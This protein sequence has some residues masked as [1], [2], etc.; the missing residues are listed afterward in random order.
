MSD[1]VERDYGS[2]GHTATYVGQP[3]FGQ[4]GG[5]AGGVAVRFA[6]MPPQFLLGEDDPGYSVVTTGKLTVEWWALATVPATV[7]GGERM[8]AKMLTLT[9]RDWEGPRLPTGEHRFRLYKFGVNLQLAETTFGFPTLGVY[10][11]YVATVENVAGTVTVTTY[12]DGAFV[13]TGT[14]AFSDLGD[15]TAKLGLGGAEDR[16]QSF[17]GT[18]DEVAIYSTKLSAARVLA[19]YQ[20]ANSQAAYTAAVLADSPLSYYHMDGVASPYMQLVPS[21][22]VD[23]VMNRAVGTRTGGD[24]Q[25]WEDV[26]SQAENTLRVRQFNSLVTTD[27]EVLNQ[28]Q[29]KIGQ[30]SQPLNRVESITVMPFVGLSGVISTTGA[31]AGRPYGS[32]LYGSGTYGGGSADPVIDLAASLG[33]EVGDKITVLETPPGFAAQQ[34]ADYIIQN[35]SGN[36]AA[37][38]S[39]VETTLTFMLWPASTT[40]FWIAGDANQSLAGISTRPGY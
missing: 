39:P 40:A 4:K 34:S 6:T 22:D 15:G 8:V 16:A 9:D 28:M 37:G 13:S 33:R 23:Q 1:V 38:Q 14:C 32:G 5:V 25:M 3:T 29:W 27:G 35:L 18:L 24:P 17:N 26:P 30:F 7:V 2:L 11:H 31:G 36:M 12:L 10:H 21:Y 20:A 19:H